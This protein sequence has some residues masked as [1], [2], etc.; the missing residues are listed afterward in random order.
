[1]KSAVGIREEF[2][3]DDAAFSPDCPVIIMRKLPYDAA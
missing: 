1:L 2:C 3:P